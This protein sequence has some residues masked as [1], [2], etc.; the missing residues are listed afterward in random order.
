MSK[1]TILHKLIE[2]ENHCSKDYNKKLKRA[3]EDIKKLLSTK[4]EEV[5]RLK[6][7]IQDLE[8][9]IEKFKVNDESMYRSDDDL[10]EHIK[11]LNKLI[12]DKD[13]EFTQVQRK[14]ENQESEICPHQQ[15]KEK[16][17]QK[18]DD[19]KNTHEMEIKK[20]DDN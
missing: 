16:L 3:N 17:Q 13:D 19:I 4:N 12:V 9:K 18:Y 2:Q 14:I 7:H 1:Q 8:Y 20:I 6:N 11:R 15:Q 10:E 5:S